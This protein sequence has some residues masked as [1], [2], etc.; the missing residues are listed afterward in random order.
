MEFVFEVFF[1]PTLDWTL[2]VGIEADSHT[3]LTAYPAAEVSVAA[4]TDCAAVG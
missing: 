1:P 3:R 2:V 4:C